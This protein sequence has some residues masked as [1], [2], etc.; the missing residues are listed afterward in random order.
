MG[1]IGGHEIQVL[2]RR[3][4]GPGWLILRG[5]W[6]YVYSILGFGG[7]E[8]RVIMPKFNKIRACAGYCLISPILCGVAVTDIIWILVFLAWYG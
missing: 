2:R 8:R 3:A 6:I 7:Q 1:R 5:I 4:S